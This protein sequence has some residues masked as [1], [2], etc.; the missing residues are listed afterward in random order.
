MDAVERPQVS[1]LIAQA[2]EKT[3][4]RDR[5]I[6]ETIAGREWLANWLLDTAQLWSPTGMDVSALIEAALELRHQTPPRVF[7]HADRPATGGVR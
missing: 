7:E 4:A 1:K 5:E 2:V 3:I 6:E